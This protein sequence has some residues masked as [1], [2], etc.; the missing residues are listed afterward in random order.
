MPTIQDVRK[1]TRPQKSYQWEVSIL[2][3]STGSLQ[4]LTVHAKTVNIPASSVD[5]IQIQYKAGKV[6]YPGRDSS[7]HTINMSFWDDE[8]Q[9]IRNYFNNWFDVLQF[10]PVTGGQAPKELCTS[11]ILIKLMDSS[12]ETSTAKIR[13]QNAFPTNMNDISL[14]YQSSEPVEVSVTFAF[15]VKINES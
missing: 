15:D 11:D 3:P 4:P 9:T 2:G 13:L 8:A 10:N 12:G 5:E 7:P 6:M 1:N 14:S